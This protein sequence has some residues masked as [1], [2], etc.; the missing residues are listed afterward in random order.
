MTATATRTMTTIVTIDPN[1][2]YSR[3]WQP[4]VTDSTHVTNRCLIA[5]FGTPLALTKDA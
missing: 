3:R 2:D 1:K 4:F 5:C